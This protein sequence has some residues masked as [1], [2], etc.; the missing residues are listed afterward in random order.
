MHALRLVLKD[1]ALRAAGL[2]L[3][4]QGAVVCTVGP[5]FST[6][7][8]HTFGFG[9]RGY[10]ILLTLASI[11]SVTAS[12]VAGIRADQTTNRRAIVMMASGCLMLGM[13]L[14]TAAPSPWSF[15]VTM[16]VLFPLASVTFG[17]VFALARMVST[18]YP[19]TDRDGIMAVIRALF[20]APFVVV[21]PLWSMAFSQGAAVLSVFP[22]GFGM[23]AMI[24]TVVTWLW[25]KDGATP[26]ADAP[27]GLRFRS[28]LSE[29][30][31][32][33]L[34]ARVLALGAV[35][36]APTIYMALI[37]LVMVGAVGR[38][39]SDVA[40][41]VG[42]VAGLEVPFMLMLPRFLPGRN[43][44]AMIVAGAGLYA[45]HVALLPLLAGTAAVWLLVLP[46]AMGGAITLTV[47]IAYLQD[48]LA[49]RPGTGAS[50]MALQRLAGDAMAAACFGIGATVSGYGLVGALAVIVSLAGAAG[51]WWAD[52]PSN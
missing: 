32:T 45:I 51:L 46:A 2:V 3:F 14:M 35:A 33:P 44:T 7:A 19:A 25:P 8:V 23:A 18:T 28:A 42:L 16:A 30:S 12:V 34:L 31:Q 9:D 5:Y 41:Y 38:G 15:A 40:L 37:S 4:L 27:S 24:L 6:L 29:M 49:D 48:L 43:R 10:A 13:G 20:A 47:P 1:P 39:P 11:W 22:V 26:W 17:Q 52:K 21:L 36:A 50:L